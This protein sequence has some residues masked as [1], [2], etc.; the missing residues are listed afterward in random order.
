MKTD[1]DLEAR[2]VAEQIRLDLRPLDTAILAV[3]AAWKGGAT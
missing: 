1:N 3:L 2:F